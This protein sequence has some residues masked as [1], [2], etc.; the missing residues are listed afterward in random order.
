MVRCVREGLEGPS[1]AKAN[2]TSEECS[3]KHLSE[4]TTVLSCFSHV[5]S[6]GQ[7]TMS[8]PNVH[9]WGRCYRHLQTSTDIYR[10]LQ[11]IPEDIFKSL[12]YLR[13]QETNINQSNEGVSLSAALMNLISESSP[14]VTALDDATRHLY[15]SA[16]SYRYAEVE[17]R[18]NWS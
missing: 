4:C 6:V 5:F 1:K 10:H 11:T 13:S 8:K 14:P 17:S 18:K 7:F 2:I 9:L 3:G 16:G 12:R 15:V